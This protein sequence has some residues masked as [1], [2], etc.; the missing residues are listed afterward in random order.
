VLYL[1]AKAL[2]TILGT[3]DGSFIMPAIIGLALFAATY[4]LW[5]GLEAVA[6]TDVVQVIMLIL[7]GIITSV[8]A[9][10]HLAPNGGVFEGF[11]VLLER[12]PQKFSMILS[13]GEIITPNGDDAYWDLPGL[14]V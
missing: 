3:G 14:S 4:S 13:R 1:G 11:G 2:D 9:L 12:A 7:G 10:Q 5:G 6:W 8:I